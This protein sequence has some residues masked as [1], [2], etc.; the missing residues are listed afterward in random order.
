[1]DG[2]RDGWIHEIAEGK[3]ATC[4]ISAHQP[5]NTTILLESEITLMWLPAVTCVRS[6]CRCMSYGP[7]ACRPSAES[8]HTLR[9]C[10][11][12]PLPISPGTPLLSCCSN[13]SHTCVR[14]VVMFHMEQGLAD[15]EV[16]TKS[17]LAKSVSP[18][19][20]SLPPLGS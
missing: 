8:P 10:T 3:E 18:L 13:R 9:T 19:P 2:R 15:M 1:M 7:R 11:P 17:S 5:R 4:T 12:T 6:P 14:P 20:P 16:V